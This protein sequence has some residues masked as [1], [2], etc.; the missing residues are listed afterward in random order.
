MAEAYA[1]TLAVLAEHEKDAALIPVPISID[2]KQGRGQFNSGKVPTFKQ[3]FTIKATINEP[4]RQD[5]TWQLVVRDYGNVIFNGKLAYERPET[6]TY[7]SP[8][9]TGEFTADVACSA[10]ID[11]KLKATLDISPG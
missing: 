6:F 11:T 4:A 3:R 7:Q 9:W 8:Y 1:D 2:V 10:P 5:L